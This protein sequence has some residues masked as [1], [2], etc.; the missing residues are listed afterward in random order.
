MWRVCARVQVFQQ[1]VTASSAP[2]TPQCFLLTPKLLPDLQYENGQITVLLITNGP[3]VRGT[4]PG[5]VADAD[6]KQA[7]H[8]F[9]P[10]N[11]QNALF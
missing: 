2:H 11:P 5:K 8:P 6:P 4:L 7:S 10:S 3:D 1:L 9:N